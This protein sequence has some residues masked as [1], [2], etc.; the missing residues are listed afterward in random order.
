MSKEPKNLVLKKQEP[1]SEEPK[2]QAPNPEVT[3]QETKK[4]ANLRANAMPVDGYVLSIDGKLKTRYDDEK[5]A[6]AA[7]AK[8]KQTYPVIQVAIYDAAKRNY[9][10]VELQEQKDEA[11]RS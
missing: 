3:V 7:G 2:V 10:P 8:L 5:I 1:K 6:M 4:P 9:T 11:A